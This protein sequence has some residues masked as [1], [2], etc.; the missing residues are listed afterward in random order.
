MLT[1][2]LRVVHCLPSAIRFGEYTVAGAFRSCA[3]KRSNQ[4]LAGQNARPKTDIAKRETG[5][6]LSRMLF[7]DASRG[8]AFQNDELQT[9]FSAFSVLPEPLYFATCG[10][11]QRGRERVIAPV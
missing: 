1:S 3:D 5:L 9:K 11:W 8:R 6:A 7:T 10:N 4:L 2:R